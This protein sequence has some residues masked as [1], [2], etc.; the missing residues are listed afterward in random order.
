MSGGDVE[1][2]ALAGAGEFFTA[3]FET[4]FGVLARCVMGFV[5]CHAFGVDLLLREGESC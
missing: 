4:P 3:P 5:P 1:L 2:V